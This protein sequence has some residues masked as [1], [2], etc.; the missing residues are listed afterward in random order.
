[1]SIEDRRNSVRKS[2]IGIDSIRKSITSL[3]QGLRAIA[4]NS[5]ELLKQTRKT[6]DLKRKIIKQDAEFFKKRREN[7]LRKQREDELEASTITGVTKRQGSLVQKS[8]R[9]FLGRI[10]DFVGI[11][12]LGWALTNLPKIIAT[13]QKLFGF[14]RRTVGILSAFVE[15]IKNFL[16]TLG[17]GIDNFLAIFNR[18]DFREDDKNIRDTFEKTDQNLNKLDQDF[19]ESVTSFAQDKDINSA[20]E[21]AKKLGLDDEDL[22]GAGEDENVPELKVGDLEDDG[23]KVVNQNQVDALNQGGTLDDEGNVVDAEGNVVEGVEAGAADLTLTEE[24]ARQQIESEDAIQGSQT[25]SDENLVESATDDDITDAI[26]DSGDV[27]GT[28]SEGTPLSVTPKSPSGSGLSSSDAAP[29]EKNVS[30]EFDLEPEE[31]FTNI[32]GMFDPVGSSDKS[33]SITPIKKNRENLNNSKKK[34][35]TVIQVNNQEAMNN[36]SNSSMSGGTKTKVIQVGQSSE[37]TLLDLQS[38]NNKHN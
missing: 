24:E 38:L 33:R 26:G 36:T 20:G 32:D 34:K 25:L 28:G 8:T 3:G 17:T 4:I 15:G 6:N 16:V 21:V 23:G 35:T 18:F 22:A 12:I 13:F 37:K 29:S 9:G 14:I 10:L 31:G 1:M 7:A 27:Q 5:Q 2:S 30:N 11:L 19:R